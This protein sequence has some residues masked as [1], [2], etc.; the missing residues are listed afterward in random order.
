MSL[1]LDPFKQ[2]SWEMYIPSTRKYT[3]LYY[4][5][6]YFYY[7][8]I[9]IY[10]DDILIFLTLIQHWKVHSSLPF[11]LF[12]NSFL[13]SKFYTI[14]LFFSNLEYTVSELLTYIPVKTNLSTRAQYSCTVILNFCQNPVSKINFICSTSPSEL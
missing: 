8:Y 5:Y 12:V 13:N 2:H 11:P 1:L 4:S 6:T 3:H 7:F 9:C 14:Y 10:I